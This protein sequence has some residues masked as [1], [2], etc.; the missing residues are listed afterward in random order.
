MHNSS[1]I[2]QIGLG[3]DTGPSSH[4]IWVSH[5]KRFIA[6]PQLTGLLN[7]WLKGAET[8]ESDIV[9]AIIPCNS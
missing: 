3:P 9:R 5:P 6:P 4:L 7:H 1:D 2:L 8:H